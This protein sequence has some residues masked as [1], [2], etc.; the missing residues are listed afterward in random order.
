MERSGLRSQF[1]TAV[2]EVKSLRNELE[3]ARQAMLELRVSG[4]CGQEEGEEEEK[5]GEEEEEGEGAEAQQKGRRQRVQKAR[6]WGYIGF[7]DVGW[8]WLTA[9]ESGLVNS[10]G[11]GSQ[12][13]SASGCSSMS[14]G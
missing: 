5:E 6:R 1:T 8:E 3:E 7:W 9:I 14:R 13:A 10:R 4:G 2:D 11:Q 12:A